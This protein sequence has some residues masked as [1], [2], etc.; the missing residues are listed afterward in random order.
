[1]QRQIPRG[2][3]RCF[4]LSLA[5]WPR[6]GFSRRQGS[7]RRAQTASGPAKALSARRSDSGAR[8]HTTLNSHVQAAGVGAA[9]LAPQGVAL[10]MF[11]AQKA[12]AFAVRCLACAS[13]AAQA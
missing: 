7:L 6:G 5:A 11:R 12:R 2:R 9:E 13:I 8:A 3:C 4:R 1:M 10:K